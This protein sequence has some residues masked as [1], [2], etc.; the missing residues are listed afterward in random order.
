MTRLSL[1]IVISRV[2]SVLPSAE[3]MGAASAVEQGGGVKP[4]QGG[5]VQAGKTGEPLLPFPGDRLGRFSIAQQKMP[6][7]R[8]VEVRCS[9][10]GPAAVGELLGQHQQAAGAERKSLIC[11]LS[12]AAWPLLVRR[13][14]DNIWSR[15]RRYPVTVTPDHHDLTL[16]ACGAG[17]AVALRTC[18]KL[19]QDRGWTA[20]LSW[21]RAG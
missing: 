7:D 9:G 1:P 4:A 13:G 10:T 14:W 6:A 12:T 21:A 8:V 15:V 11:C 3:M 20:G 16:V 5:H 2:V 17:P 18:A 19:A